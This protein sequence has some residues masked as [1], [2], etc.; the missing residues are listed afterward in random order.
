MISQKRTLEIL[1]KA[2]YGDT[3]SRIFDISLSFLI[4]ANLAAVCLESVES[5]NNNFHQYFLFFEYI[6]VLIFTIEYFLR[7]WVQAINV[8]SPA[9]STL[10]RRI[11]YIFSFTGMIDLLAILPSLLPLVAGGLDL[12]WLRVLRMA[13]LLKISHYS[14]ALEDLMSTVYEERKSLGAALYLFLIAIFLSSAMLYLAENKAQPEYFS[15]IPQTMWWSIITLT[16]VGYGDVSPITP[17]GQVFGAIT[18]VMGVMSVALLT[19]IVASGF[20]NQMSR[21]KEIVEAEIAEALS[22]GVITKEEEK[23][24]DELRKKLNLSEDHVNSI[25]E[26]LRR[27]VVDKNK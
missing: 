16:T 22:D 18:A 7:I 17:L 20:S 12:R 13:R 1:S 26:M 2:K 25:T 5:I 6:S 24:I 14:S 11:R 10:M 4:L 15:S 9:K 23:H 8:D 19:G 27:E 3:A 21:R